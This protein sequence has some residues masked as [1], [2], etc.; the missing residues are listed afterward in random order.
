MHALKLI[1]SLLLAVIALTAGLFVTAVVALV[2]LTLFVGARLFGRTRF[3]MVAPQWRTRSSSAARPTHSD[4][5]EVTA[6]EVQNEPARS[7]PS[8]AD[9][10]ADERVRE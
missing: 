1:V 10:D 6:T 3:R 4:A 2:G 9:A 7:L 5:I 8:G